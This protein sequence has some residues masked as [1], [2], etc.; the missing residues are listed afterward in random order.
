MTDP[1]EPDKH[2]RCWHDIL[3]A[4]ARWS[5]PALCGVLVVL[6]AV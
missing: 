6:L 3:Y 4:V 5:I 2:K 1:E